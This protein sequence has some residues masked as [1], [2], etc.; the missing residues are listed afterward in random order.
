MVGLFSVLALSACGK[1]GTG[2]PKPYQG[3]FVDASNTTTMTI[4]KDSAA[5][6]TPDT[7]ISAK[8]QK[9]S[10]DKLIGGQSG[11]F[12]RQKVGTN[13]IEVFWITPDT[14]SRNEAGG[15]IYFTS[16]IVYIQLDPT[17][18]DK[19]QLLTVIHSKA[20]SV[21]LDTVTKT[22]QAGWPAEVQELSL[23][24]AIPAPK[25]KSN[26]RLN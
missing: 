2:I 17:V 12:L 11:F 21:M 26:N 7:N 5:L 9:L 23:M 10:Y 6:V 20:G 18:K 13:L 16:D 19:V 4:Q 8:V 24:R 14:T 1:N 15:I 22:W 25:P 3:T